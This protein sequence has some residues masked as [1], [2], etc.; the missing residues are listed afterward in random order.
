MAWPTG[1][2]RAA[3]K[4]ALP[5]ADR[6]REPQ[7]LVAFLDLPPEEAKPTL[8]NGTHSGRNETLS[9][10]VLLISQRDGTQV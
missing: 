3:Y 6:F 8:K 5:S 1:T 10:P 7:R 9:A 4:D 2:I